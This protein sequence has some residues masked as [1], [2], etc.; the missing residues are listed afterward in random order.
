MDKIDQI[1][2]NNKVVKLTK[3][4]KYNVQRNS[5]RNAKTFRLPH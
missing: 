5:T 3:P 1:M 2:I 4:I